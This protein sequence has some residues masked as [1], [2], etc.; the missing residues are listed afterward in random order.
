MFRA[1]GILVKHAKKI[2]TNPK[3]FLFIYGFFPK[4]FALK[5]DIDVKVLLR[6]VRVSHS[7]SWQGRS[8]TSYK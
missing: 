4:D 3:S 7:M 8:P 6:G 2:G 5:N 1:L